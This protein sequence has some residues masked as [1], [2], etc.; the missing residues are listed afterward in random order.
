[1]NSQ[2]GWYWVALGVFALGLTNNLANGGGRKLQHVVEHS[3][4]VAQN[5]SDRIAGHVESLEIAL[6]D[7]PNLDIQTA[8]IADNLQQRVVCER[9]KVIRQQA[10][11]AKV[12]VA[13][14]RIAKL[15]LAPNPVV[16][17]PKMNFQVR[18]LCSGSDGKRDKI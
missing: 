18:A 14:V 2:A 9:I 1:M 11:L 10:A 5:I 13:K 15:E 6:A 3:V 16:V 17:T 12:E 8:V 4:Q 7:K